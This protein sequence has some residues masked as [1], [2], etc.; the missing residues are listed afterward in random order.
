MLS[1]HKSPREE[2]FK[3]KYYEIFRELMCIFFKLFNGK[4]ISESILWGQLHC[5]MKTKAI[6][7]NEN[8]K[9]MLLMNIDVKVLSKILENQ[10]KP[11]TD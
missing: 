2:G 4:N 6:T 1:T 5:D 11:T 7:E 8:Y 10:V 9:P 3:G